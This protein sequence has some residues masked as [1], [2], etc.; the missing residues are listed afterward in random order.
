MLGGG[1]LGAMIPC[2]KA[3]KFTPPITQH[4]REEFFYGMEQWCVCVCVFDGSYV[5][6]LTTAEEGLY[7]NT[8]RYMYCASLYAYRIGWQPT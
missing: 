2:C 6:Y 1:G 4:R 3:A 8:V 5:S 7:I